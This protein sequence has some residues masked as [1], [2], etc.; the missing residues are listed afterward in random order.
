MGRESV[1]KTQTILEN[2]KNFW[3][4]DTTIAEFKSKYSFASVF[5]STPPQWFQG[6]ISLF[7]SFMYLSDF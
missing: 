2:S 7:F 5:S 1:L 3:I 4:A 6:L